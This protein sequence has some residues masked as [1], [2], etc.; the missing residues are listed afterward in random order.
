VYNYELRKVTIAPPLPSMQMTDK[1]DTEEAKDQN[2]VEFVLM[3][4]NKS[5]IIS[6]FHDN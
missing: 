1:A 6:K 3:T 5:N 4:R 2:E